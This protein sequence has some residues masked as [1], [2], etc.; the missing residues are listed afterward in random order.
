[1]L[2]N[3]NY[4]NFRQ[5]VFDIMT[6]CRHTSPEDRE[7]ISSM[8]TPKLLREALH[9]KVSKRRSKKQADDS[10]DRHET[11]IDSQPVKE[12]S[13]DSVDESS[14]ANPFEDKTDDSVKQYEH[15]TWGAVMDSMTKN[16]FLVMGKISNIGHQAQNF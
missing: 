16:A 8:S 11:T 2:A 3:L 13:I 14:T 6:F 9:P 15:C 5:P 4:C 12:Q 10:S 7:E 1:M